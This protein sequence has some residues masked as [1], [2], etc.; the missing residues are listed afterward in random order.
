M[1]DNIIETKALVPYVALEEEYKN[2]KFEVLEAS[3][4]VIQKVKYIKSID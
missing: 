3:D 2:V 1:F 4:R